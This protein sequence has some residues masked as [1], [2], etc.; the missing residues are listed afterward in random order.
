MEHQAI[1]DQV[2]R[3]V[4]YLYKEAKLETGAVVVLGCSSSEVCGIRIG[5]GRNPEIGRVLAGAFLDSCES[6]GLC[7]AVQCCEHLNRALVMERTTLKRLGLTQVKARPVPEAGGSTAAA[8]YDRFQNPVLAQSIQ[9]D[10]ALDIGDTLV[11]MHIRPVAVPLRMENPT[12]GEAHVVMAY[13]RVPLIGGERAVY[14]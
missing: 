12:V 14:E 9:A 4:Q 3:C 10:A 11:G 1:Y 2:C 5:K 7:G 13:A 8:A 6:L